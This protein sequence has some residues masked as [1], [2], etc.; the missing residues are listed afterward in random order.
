MSQADYVLIEE[1]DKWIELTLNRPANFN[2]LSEGM[3]HALQHTLHDIAKREDLSCV[4]LKATGKAF[5][6]GHDLKEMAAKVSDT[7]Y[8][9]LFKQ[10][11]QLMQSIIQLPIPVIAEV[12]GVATAAGCQLVATCDLAVASEQ[13]K[14]A[15]S[16]INLGLFCSTPAVALSRSIAPKHAMEMLLT[17]E[18]I[19]AA[20]AQQKG[21]INRVASAEGLTHASRALAASI[22]KKM[23][24]AIKTGKAMF[25]PQLEKPLS[26]AYTFASEY[27]VCNIMATETQ[28]GITNFVNKK[29]L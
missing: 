7:Y 15:V 6:A 18:F 25:Y 20:E 28:T 24:V 10:C 2:T 11:S 3:M 19:S 16:G 1:H 14:F 27:M 12:Q 13:A 29:K 4:I 9:Q 26:E 22:S 23:P 21:L 5:S 8:Q 17:G